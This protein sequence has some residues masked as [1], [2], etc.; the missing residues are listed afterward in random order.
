M[1][2]SIAPILLL[3]TL[4]AGCGTSGDVY[5]GPQIL[6][7]TDDPRPIPQ[8]KPTRPEGGPLYVDDSEMWT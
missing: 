6:L 8:K 2:W 5:R 4:L 1:K 3:A 7:D